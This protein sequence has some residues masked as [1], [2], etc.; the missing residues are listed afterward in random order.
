MV[1]ATKPIPFVDLK[2]QYKAIRPEIDAAVQATIEETAF[3]GGKRLQ[4]L[5]EAFAAY[6]GVRFG[7][8]ASSGTTAL[9]I[10]L[11][12]AG[13]KP[14]DEIIVP[15]HTFVAT[16][17]AVHHT[18]A[19]PIFVD[20]DPE[21]YCMDPASAEAAVTPR[22]K[23]IMPVHI[24]GQVTDMDP[25][26]ELAKRKNL[27]VIED[28]AQ[29]HGAY[30]GKKRAGS[31]GDFGCFSFYP[32]K[33]LGAYGDAGMSV[34]N[35]EE[36]AKLMT[37]LVNHGRTTKYEH[38]II[39]YNYRLDGIQAAVLNV[40]LPHLDDWNEGRRRAAHRYNELLKDLDVV[41]P[42]E[43]RGHVYHLYVIQCDD[44]EGLGKA[45]GEDGI[46]SGVHYPVPLHL[47]PCFQSHPGYGKGKLPV[48]EKVA[49]RILSLPM[50]PELTEEQQ[51][52]VA[53]SIRKFQG[54]SI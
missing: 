22:T 37:L 4:A 19:V 17:E 6:C 36:A 5:E 23:G 30:Y 52:R 13:V 31:M 50:F 48:T 28:A 47:Q 25:I 40:K 2:S 15:S 46:A 7:V 45:L 44:R 8:G 35:D 51:G 21:T 27:F 14:G 18:G 26:L 34:T 3:I 9:H 43:K 53:A 39:G 49:S 20:I 24:Y 16:A 41:T 29:S 32:G 42:V 12:A 11:A 38:D 1:T 33:N 54:R 10:A